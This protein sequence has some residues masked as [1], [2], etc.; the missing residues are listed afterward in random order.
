MKTIAVLLA[1]VTI[2]LGWIEPASVDLS[3]G[4][5]AYYPFDGNAD[6][7]SGYEHH[8][9][10]NGAS[11]EEGLSGQSLYFGGE[12]Q[13]V[14]MGDP[15]DGRLDF[16]IGSLALACWFRTTDSDGGMLLYKRQCSFHGFHHEGYSI[17]LLTAGRLSM[18]LEDTTGTEGE[19]EGATTGLDD[20]EWHHLAAVRDASAGKVRL[21]VDGK[22]DTLFREFTE[23]GWQ[24][25]SATQ[26]RRGRAG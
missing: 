17:S 14:N 1:A 5:V 23:K 10:L 26:D 15:A 20:G 7:A 21:Y 18:T 8:G 24:L 22:L 2:V 6:D 12:N 19:V 11:Y 4:L 9:L 16:G 25:S 13:Y 3:D